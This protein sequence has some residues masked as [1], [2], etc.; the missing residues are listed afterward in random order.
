MHLRS[1]ALMFRVP[2]LNLCVHAC[3]C[4]SMCVHLDVLR[5]I[6]SIQR[7]IESHTGAQQ[8]Q[9]RISQC[10]EYPCRSRRSHSHSHIQQSQSQPQNPVNT[11]PIERPP[12]NLRSDSFAFHAARTACLLVSSS[13]FAR[14]SSVVSGLLKNRK[15]SMEKHNMARISRSIERTETRLVPAESHTPA[16]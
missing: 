13:L 4:E 10:S 9:C 6:P 2:R 7:D 5:C 15:F 3:P 8:M 16:W 11:T 1:N 12:H 14:K